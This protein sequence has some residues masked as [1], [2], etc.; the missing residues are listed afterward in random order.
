VQRQV[1]DD[2]NTSKSIHNPRVYLAAANLIN[3]KPKGAW[4]KAGLTDPQKAEAV[5]IARR[6]DPSWVPVEGQY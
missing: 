5:A 1:D 4:D 3:G 6:A 2:W